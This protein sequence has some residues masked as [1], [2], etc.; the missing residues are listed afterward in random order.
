MTTD[1]RLIEAQSRGDGAALTQAAKLALDLSECRPEDVGLIVGDGLGADLDDLREASAIEAIQDGAPAVFAASTASLG[2]TGAA[3]GAFSFVHACL[4]LKRQVLP[5]LIN[6]DHPDPRC[7]VRFLPL[8]MESQYKRAMVWNSD[9]GIK[10]V[11]M[12]LGSL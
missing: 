5:P 3:S 12:V 7:K 11:A 10:N 2:F 6:C 1:T 8:A 9:R 4:A